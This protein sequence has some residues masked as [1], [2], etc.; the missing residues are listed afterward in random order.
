M[1]QFFFQA[2]MKCVSPFAVG[3]GMRGF[4]D[5]D[6]LTD[7]SG[8][9]FVPGASIAGSCRHYL[10]TVGMD[11]SDVF[12][13]VD[14]EDDSRIVFYE[15]FA[16]DGQYIKGFRDGVAIDKVYGTA[17]EGSRF[18]YEIVEVGSVFS[19]RMMLD[20]KTATER[21]IPNRIICGINSGEIRIGSKT[22]RG[23][24]R[25]ILENMRYCVIT[26]I[27]DLIDFSWDVMQTYQEMPIAE[28]LQKTYTYDFDVKSFTYVSNKATLYCH[29]QDRV[30]AAEQLKNA[31]GE[32]VIPGTSWAGVFRHRMYRILSEVGYAQ[33]ENLLNKLFGTQQNA[34]AIVFEESVIRDDYLIDQTRNAIDRFTGGAGDKKLFTNRLSVG[35]VVTLTV[36]MK[37]YML[38]EKERIMAEQL[39][40]ACVQD[41]MDGIIYVGGMGSVGGGRMTW[42]GEEQA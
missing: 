29:E 3:S 30:V 37:H 38:D 23:M 9:P 17:I 31:H 12:G 35:G 40:E 2:D 34:S 32:S 25:V 24:G 39:L 14:N 19:F 15:A 10:E 4:T 7:A 21:E 5:K 1:E 27:S 26:D 33:K 6:V 22:S 42:H 28:A 13:S 8:V 16:K 18:D 36:H 11:V 41:L 20:I